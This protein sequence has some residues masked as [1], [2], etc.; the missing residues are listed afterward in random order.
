M[1]QILLAAVLAW[2]ASCE[3]YETQRCYADADCQ[4]DECANAYCPLQED[5]W[6]SYYG[7]CTHDIIDPTGTGSVIP[8]V[9]A[10]NKCPPGTFR[11][12]DMYMYFCSQC[13]RGTYLSAPTQASSCLLCSAGTYQT[14]VMS[15]TC[16]LCSAGKYQTG[17]RAMKATD[18]QTCQAGKYAS[19]AGL[20]VC[21]ECP[22][23]AYQDEVGG[24][25]AC[26]LC[27]PGR[28][29][30]TTG[31]DSL[32]S[33]SECNR[34]KYTSGDGQSVC[35][36]CQAGS[37]QQSARS[38]SCVLCESGSF[39]SRQGNTQGCD[40]CTAGKFAS[41]VGYGECQN[42]SAGSY[43]TG[44]RGAACVSCLAG[45]YQTG[46]GTT[47]EC[48]ACEP[49][50]YTQKDGEPG[51]SS[52]TAG[53]YQSSPAS[54]GCD[55]CGA[56]TFST[57]LAAV[58]SEACVSCQEGTYIVGNTCAGCTARPGPD[59]FA[60]VKCSPFGDA[61]WQ[62][63]SAACPAGAVQRAPCS[64]TSDLECGWP[65]GDARCSGVPANMAGVPEWLPAGLKCQRGQYLYG[66]RSLTDKDCRPCPADTISL[67]GFSCEACS[68]PLEEPYWLDHSLC[69]C[70]PPAVLVMAQGGCVCPAGWAQNGS[71]C[72]PCAAG[73]QFGAGPG[74]GC[75]MCGPGT[76]SPA[77]GATSCEVCASGMYRQAGSPG[78]CERCPL[79]G[80]Y[81]PDATQAGCERCETSCAGRPGW[82]DGGAC[83]GG[84]RVCVPCA[85][86]PGNATWR[87]G[88]VYECDAGFYRRG[89]GCEA[90]STK[91]CEA[92]RRWEAC[93]ADADRRCDAECVNA[94]KPLLN[95]RWVA[96]TRGD[97]PWECEEGFALVRTDYWVFALEECVAAA[98]K[99]SVYY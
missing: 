41:G 29:R 49:G 45:Q 42:C 97:C 59:W 62:R 64:N 9:C 12:H 95:S 99:E 6:G 5:G 65:G 87:G 13:T 58:S 75:Q 83:P 4:N 79:D 43:Q 25:T 71:A 67:N 73:S 82:T 40:W 37:Y 85:A 31:G 15:S 66:F 54:T 38:S 20:A 92:G 35:S 94:S 60:L 28:M 34:G 78:G 81:A 52:C 22:P 36:D 69:V 2:L 39:Q 74:L 90:C 16:A 84:W 44:L 57:A 32:A 88:C 7:Y 3:A 47:A 72:V 48:P 50:K 98:Q 86:L 23:G 51:C 10:V 53:K 19:A 24:T 46:V 33:C 89:G 26:K 21:P 68:G 14:G 91:A 63:C 80:W 56:G 18:C 77:A 93:S 96:G 76:F 61:R 11:D 70:R 1:L 55:G 30:A 17:A 27:P 8:V